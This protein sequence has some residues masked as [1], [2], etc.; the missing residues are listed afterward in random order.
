M[1]ARLCAAA[2]LFAALGAPAMAAP[3]LLTG[4]RVVTNVA[5]PL[6]RADVLIDGGKVVA[7]GPALEA[8]PGT[9]RIDVSGKWVTPGLFAV[10]SRVGLADVGAADSSDTSAGGENAPTAALDAAPAFN[11]ATASVA[12]S[13]AGGVLRAA[14][15]PSSNDGFLSGRGAIVSLSGA[16]SSILAPRAF[17]LID[18]GERGASLAGGARTALWPQFEAALDDALSYPERYRAGQ[19]GAVLGELDAQ[20]LQ[21]FAR[22][23]GLLLVAAHRASDLRQ[24][25][26]LKRRRPALRLAILGAT[27]G[28][29]V[30]SELAAAQIPVIIDP[31]QALPDSFEQLGARLDNAALL[32]AAG[33]EVS[34]GFTPGSDET[35]QNRLVTQYAGNAAANGLPWSAAF[36]A[37]SMRPAKVFGQT[38]FGRI[39]PGAVADLVVWDGDPLDVT[40]AAVK[41]Y[42]AGVEAPLQTRQKALFERYRQIVLPPAP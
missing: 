29:R 6:E 33:V 1:I 19:G 15:A 21:P 18:L 3:L 9:E 38:E 27:E 28:W 24:V 30:A 36:A 8:P 37:I 17:L 35:F 10:V 13:R 42:I 7:V 12:A 4:G 25:I 20:A 16:P 11:P 39:A 34:I 41:A 5:E 26:A 2:A 22:G 23:Q 31:M 14:I 32:E 40:S